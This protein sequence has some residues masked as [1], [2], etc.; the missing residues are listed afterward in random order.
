MLFFNK[1]IASK[2]SIG[3]SLLFAIALISFT[4]INYI[5]SR[6]NSIK[7]LSLERQKAVA[8]SENILDIEL[9]FDAN[10]AEQISKQISKPNLTR[11][12]VQ[13][14]L[15]TTNKITEFSSI[16]MVYESDGTIKEANSIYDVRKYPWYQEA[17][18]KNKLIITDPYQNLDNNTYITLAAPIHVENKFIGVLGINLEAENLSK[19][20]IKLGETKGGYIM[21]LDSEGKIIMHQEKNQ[22]GKSPN[23]TL[24][25]VNNF[26]NK[27]ID[28]YGMISYTRS[29]GNQNIADC[30]NSKHSD[31]IICASMDKNI[32][33]EGINNILKK[34]LWLSALY[35][36]SHR[37]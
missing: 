3:V 19:K 4:Y 20:I 8:G 35:I 18:K 36:L 1:S 25:L 23:S 11:E 2:I 5:D 17:L 13:N 37:L 12:E 28:K 7:L 33:E 31:W 30:M 34:Q 22:I 27:N 24:S 9:E 26:Q 21:I 14:I 15:K 29:N 16:H 6:D 10:K 32:F